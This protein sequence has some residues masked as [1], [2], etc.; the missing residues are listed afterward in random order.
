[1][2]MRETNGGKCVKSKQNITETKKERDRDPI[3]RLCL[4]DNVQSSTTLLSS[5]NNFSC[6]PKLFSPLPG[7][8]PQPKSSV[9]YVFAQFFFL[10]L[11]L[12]FVYSSGFVGTKAL[13]TQKLSKM[14]MMLFTSSCFEERYPGYPPT[15]DHWDRL[16]HRLQ[17]PLRRRVA[18]MSPQTRKGRLQE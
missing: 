10:F 3:A 13:H 15:L 1:M 9:V 11:C 12:V 2:P 7:E 6:S 18:T 4:T 16:A 5:S 8:S 14:K 17:G